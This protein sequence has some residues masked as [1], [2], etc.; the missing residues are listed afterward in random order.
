[1][2][3]EVHAMNI[4]NN[5]YLDQES[6]FPSSHQYQRCV[7]ASKRIS[8]RI[9]EDVIRSREFDRQ[10]KF[11]PDSLSLVQELSFLGRADQ[12]FFSQIQGRTYANIFG[13]VERF[14]NAKVLELGQLYVLGD[15]VAL[16]ALVRFSDEE[17]KHQ[18]LFRRIEMMTAAVM[19]EGYS[20]AIEPNEVAQAV[21][22][23]S[24]WAVLGLTCHIELF[25]QQH[26]RQSIAF[27]DGLSPLYKDVFLFHWREESQ[28]AVLDE[29]EWREE[30]KKL[31]VQQRDEAV[32]D[33]IAL[34][35]AVDQILQQQAEADAAYFVSASL[36]D[37]NEQQKSAIKVT[38][39][40]AYR[41]QYIVSGLKHTRFIH[42]LAELVSQTQMDRINQALAPLME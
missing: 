12:V 38:F 19:P 39:L 11:L 36:A 1:M 13:L 15:Q 40:R 27:G 42:I 34:V 8:W 10:E 3:F 22:S 14:I 29:I 21:L 6:K 5:A 4:M 41:W 20:F 16:E 18:A 25:T 23:K 32:D 17:I 33:L 7:M 30:D 37:Y 26:Y 31:S 24:T 28:H 2:T 9:E 35:S